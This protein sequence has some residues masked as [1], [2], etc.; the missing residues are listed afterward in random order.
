MSAPSDPEAGLREEASVPSGQNGGLVCLPASGTVLGDRYRLLEAIDTESYL[1]EDLALH[2]RVTVRKATVTE[3]PGMESWRERVLQLVSAR[4]PNF[5]N[6]LDWIPEGSIDFVVTECAKGNSV[7]ELL[8]QCPA[9]G[10]DDAVG[11]LRALGGALDL[12]AA[13]ACHPNP[14]STRGLFV[15]AGDQVDGQVDLKV[16]SSDPEFRIKIDAWQLVKLDHDVTRPLV[17]FLEKGGSRGL[18]VQQAALLVYEL[19]GGE[20]PQEGEIKG[21]FK[22]SPGLT[23]AANSILY[24]SLQGWPL[25]DSSESFFQALDSANRATSENVLDP[26]DEPVPVLELAS[27]S[28]PSARSNFRRRRLNRRTMVFSTL[29][30]AGLGFIAVALTFLLSGHHQEATELKSEAAQSGVVSLRSEP[31]GATVHLDGS[32]LGHTP[33]IRRSLPPGNHELAVSLPSFQERDLQIEVNAG[34]GQDLGNIVLRQIGG[35]LLLDAD[36]PGTAYEVTGADKKSF[37]GVTPAKLERLDPGSYAVHLRP[38]GWPE[39]QETVQISSGESVSVDHP[40]A[41]L[42]SP[43]NPSTSDAASSDSDALTDA[44][45][46]GQSQPDATLEHTRERL[47]KAP[48]ES[49]SRSLHKAPLTKSETIKRFDAEWDG[50]ENAIERQI[51]AIDQRIA[52]ASGEKKNRLKVWKKYLGQRKHYVRE[53]RRY[54]EYALRREWDEKHGTGTIFDSIRDALGI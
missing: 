42:S 46:T 27:Y 32:D 26:A 23:D 34:E 52:V 7:A 39:Y 53:L 36:L 4:H 15:E 2:Q 51:S 35:E 21:W 12:T 6:I 11:L 37:T 48:L 8:K 1:A 24:G 25:F 54:N 19:L 50:K 41:A 40:F 33:I 20:E 16:L 28:A 17:T 9:L 43:V 18:A 47:A 45:A 14:L 38:E 22:P 29:A 44:P 10:L 49:R 5:L 13:F 30:T 3:R 31:S